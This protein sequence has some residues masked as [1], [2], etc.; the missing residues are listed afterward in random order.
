MTSAE[1]RQKYLDFFVSFN[2]AL[3]SSASL[4]PEND[5]TVL[6]T[7]AGM[8]PLV[9]YLMGEKHP[10]GSRLTSAQKCVRTGDIDEVGDATHHTLFEM[11]GNWSLGDYFK[12]EAINYSFEFL[13]DKKWLGLDKNRLAVSVFKGDE[14]APY[15]EEAHD[16]WLSLG[17]DEK[18]IARLPKKNNWWGPAGITGPCGSDTEIFYWVGDQN[19]VPESFNDDN[20]LWVEIWN[21]VFMQYNKNAAGKFEL[22]KQKNVD[23]GLGLERV[24]AVMNGFSDN[25]QTD[26]FENIIKKIEELSEHQYTETP[27]IT[28]AMRIIAD[29]LKA[30][31]FI[32]GD[33]KGVAPSNTDQG[34]IVRRL[35]RRAIRYGKQLGIIRDAWITSVAKVVVNDYKNIYRELSRNQ[36]FIFSNLDQEEKKFNLTLE[37]GLL[38]FNKL[39]N[40][41]IDAKNAFALYQSYGFPLEITEELANENK[42]KVDRVGFYEELKKHQDLSRTASAGKFKGGLADS[43]EETTK[44]HTATHL[45]IAALRKVLGDQ[46]VQRGANITT[47]RLRLDFSYPEKMTA[48][49]IKKVE[50]LVNGAI[51]Q[52]Y[53]VVCEE[54]SLTEAKKR[55]A[56]GIFDSKYGEKVKVYTVCHL[57]DSHQI[58]FSDV[59]SQEIC[60]G[61]HVK[62]TGGLGH[63]KIQKEEASSAGVRRIKAILENIN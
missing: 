60:G 36:E 18:R 2:H 62:E 44:L 45:M 1:L 11:M 58:N 27:E 9:P 3:I 35:I 26:L 52:N 10:A 22:L 15:D 31:T 49:Q 47:E 51:S 20:D 30:A 19:K 16:I 6:F 39:K 61:P 40:K 56:M 25:Y 43:G 46:V 24:L 42:I 14:D 13:T 37:K 41:D 29:H 17:I 21:N 34:Y 54:L 23:T 12:K 50:D 57:D 33:D 7:T 55:G 48:E 38:E 4:I 59:F 63:F 5:P 8:H 28:K 32:I 53:G